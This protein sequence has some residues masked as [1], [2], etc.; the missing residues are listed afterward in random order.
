MT[1]QRTLVQREY[2]RIG[3]LIVLT[4][5]SV[6]GENQTCQNSFKNVHHFAHV[7]VDRLALN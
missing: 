1:S 4:Y 2:Q 5:K 6:S 7:S 3:H